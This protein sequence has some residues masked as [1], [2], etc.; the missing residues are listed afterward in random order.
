MNAHID[1]SLPGPRGSSNNRHVTALLV[2][3]LIVTLALCAFAGMFVFR[4][5]HPFPAKKK[6]VLSADAAKD[7]AVTLEQQG[8]SAAAAGAWE[9]YLKHF[10]PGMEDAAKIWF[11]VG[12]LFQDAHEYAPALT[13]YYRSERIKKIDSISPEIGRRVADCLE[14]MGKFSA[15]NHELADRVG[16]GKPGADHSKVAA[17]IGPD[18]ITI[19]QIDRLIEKEVDEKL[20]TM[21]AFMTPEQL[22]KEKEQLID[23][24]STSS[25]RES[26]L[27][28]YLGTE[29][30]YREAMAAGLDNDPK[31]MDRINDDKKSILAAAML[32]KASADAIKIMPDDIATYFQ[33]HKAEYIVPAAVKISEIIVKDQDIAKKLRKKLAKCE[34]FKSLAKRY[35]IHQKS[36]E[37][38]DVTR[39]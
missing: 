12:K 39:T 3:N 17:E 27:R 32:E 33:A 4:N 23:R 8:L 20:L 28:R 26:F 30:L 15:L 18:K 14:S 24:M 5:N 38:N 11:R 35:S 19:S 31:I 22:K 37:N 9:D 10:P 13:A 2:I 6:P 29:L 1:F 25:E 21:N 7:L 36:G 16:M 34:N